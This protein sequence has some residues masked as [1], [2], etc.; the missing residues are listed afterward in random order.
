ML[1]VSRSSAPFGLFVLVTLDVEDQLVKPSRVRWLQKRR[2]PLCIVVSPHLRNQPLTFLLGESVPAELTAIGLDAEQRQNPLG[3][4]QTRATM[5]NATT[6][7]TPNSRNL[8]LIGRFTDQKFWHF[9]DCAPRSSGVM[10]GFATSWITV[11]RSP[12]RVK[13]AHSRPDTVFQVG[14]T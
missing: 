14:I 3:P 5:S 6:R 7:R 10:T 1:I 8:T 9:S 13:S 11:A 2:K 12:R 4:T